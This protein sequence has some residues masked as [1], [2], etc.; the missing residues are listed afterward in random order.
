MTHG[1]VKGLYSLSFAVLFARLS[2][3]FEREG[4]EQPMPR[5]LYRET[6]DIHRGRD[7]IVKDFLNGRED[8][9]LWIDCD[10]VFGPDLYEQLRSVDRPIVSGLA[11]RRSQ[12]FPALAFSVMRDGAPKYVRRCPMERAFTADRVGSAC[13]LVQRKVYEEIEWPWYA[14]WTPE[15]I[16]EDYLFC[17]RARKAGFEIWIEPRALVDHIGDYRYSV[18]DWETTWKELRKADPAKFQATFV[19]I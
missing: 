10:M 1:D 11:V 9:L 16:G 14:G 12:S 17:D 15:H 13:T 7:N 8:C 2:I 6:S 3:R 19:D 5:I 4:Y 18:D